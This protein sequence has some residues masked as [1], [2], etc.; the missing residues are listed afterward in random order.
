MLADIFTAT[1]NKTEDEL[2]GSGYLQAG[3]NGV[4]ATIKMDTDGSITV[5]GD[6]GLKALYGKEDLPSDLAT[7]AEEEP[8]LKGYL[9][10]KPDTNNGG[11]GDGSGGSGT[12]GTSGP[13]QPSSPPAVL[14]IEEH[15]A[16][17]VG[18]PDGEVKPGNSITRAEIATILFR[19]L[20]D[21]ARGAYW[22]SADD[23]ENGIAFADVTD[24][25]TTL[26]IPS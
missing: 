12:S 10:T 14:D 9:I 3:H 20:T 15:Y 26:C 7:M 22:G 13:P 8:E 11:S 18:F 1:D 21:E 23:P 17:V 4:F 16:Y 5:T 6:P 19:L 24:G 2:T 25:S